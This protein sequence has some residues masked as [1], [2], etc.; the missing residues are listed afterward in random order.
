MEDA[1]YFLIKV[2]GLG[3]ILLLT[4]CDIIF[5]LIAYNRID[6][7]SLD[8]CI[9]STVH[10]LFLALADQS[11]AWNY[12]V[13]F[14]FAFLLTLVAVICYRQLLENSQ[15]DLEKTFLAKE[16]TIRSD[17]YVVFSRYQHAVIPLIEP[18]IF[19]T[20]PSK[21]RVRRGF[22]E[23]ANQI[24]IGSFDAD[25]DDFRVPKK[26]FKMLYIFSFF[27]F[28]VVSVLIAIL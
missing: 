28:P 13:R 18:D 14:I 15:D 9:F 4:V 10:S 3:L 23:L 1:F 19:E 26:K 27:I 16:K 11:H 8:I 2:P 12:I 5:R 17:R 25:G 20:R 6:S 22:A 7:V 24:D 21:K